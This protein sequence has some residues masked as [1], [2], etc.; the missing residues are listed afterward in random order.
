MKTIKIL[1]TI[2]AVILTGAL[3]W[4]AFLP[5]TIHIKQSRAIKAPI[6]VVFDQV[7]NLRNWNNWSPY[8]DSVLSS[9]F[10]GPE[11]GVGATI[12]WT[13]K[14]QGQAT[15]KIIAAVEHSVLKL[16]TVSP[17]QEKPVEMIFQ[18]EQIGDSTYISWERNIEDLSYPM[19]RFVGWMLEKGYNYNFAEGLKGLKYF[20][21][22]NK[23]APEYYGYEVIERADKGGRFLAITDSSTAGNMTQLIAENYHAI[24][25]YMEQLGME[26]IG[27][28]R[29]QWHSYNP[30]GYSSFSCLIPIP[31]DSNNI[32]PF[33][34]VKLYTIPAHQLAVI[35]YVGRYELSYNAWMALDNYILHNSLKMAGDPWEKYVIDPSME[36]DS[37]KL[38]TNICFPYTKH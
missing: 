29:I 12:I 6:G 34:K 38:I 19:N 33:E 24:A 2:L 10:E 36:P 23:S 32:A 11:K 14:K 15:M 13:D 1:S 8:K 22:S 4:A 35:S 25:S 18:F 20:I 7:N 28:N 5:S 16:E 30:A 21:E 26:A 17:D 9:K 37:T 3:I 31:N 27:P